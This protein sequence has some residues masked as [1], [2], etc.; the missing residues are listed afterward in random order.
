MPGKKTLLALMLA[1]AAAFWAPREE[2]ATPEP[3]RSDERSAEDERQLRNTKARLEATLR[4]VAAMRR[5]SGASGGGS[6]TAPDLRAQPVT[7][8]GLHAL[9]AFELELAP[10]EAVA[11]RWQETFD[12][13]RQRVV[14]EQDE[15]SVYVRLPGD[16]AFDQVY[17]MQMD[18]GG[19]SV[20]LV[21]ET[22]AGER[23]T[24]GTL[25]SE[26]G[27]L[28]PLDFR[29]FEADAARWIEVQTR[30]QLRLAAAEAAG[31]QPALERHE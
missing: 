3:A 8:E 18:E 15:G 11:R 21:G 2:P 22:A 13:M 9:E 26:E 12:D 31:V 5:E 25:L 10:S 30:N 20:E 1:G 14:I 28:G 4:V 24:V 17:T 7:K 19:T 27:A 16:D 23:W 29:T 6:E